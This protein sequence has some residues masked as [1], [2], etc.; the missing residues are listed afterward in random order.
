MKEAGLLGWF[1]MARTGLCKHW[2][3]GQSA[4]NSF[5]MMR[6][7]PAALSLRVASL[8]SPLP[9]PQASDRERLVHLESYLHE[10]VV[11]QDTGKQLLHCSCSALSVVQGPAWPC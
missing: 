3:C 7:H 5:R 11:G 4:L 10:R 1:L 6:R 9:G 2:R 8:P